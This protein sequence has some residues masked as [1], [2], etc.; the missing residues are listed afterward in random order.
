MKKLISI[1]IMVIMVT[2][3]MVPRTAEAVTIKL[4]KS[5]LLLGVGS[6]YVLHI[7]GTTKKVIWST[8]DSLVATVSTKGKV[9]AIAPGNATINATISKKKLICEI[10][11]N[12]VINNSDTEQA[13]Q[14][15]DESIKNED[16][17]MNNK[18]SKDIAAEMGKGWNLGNTMEAVATWLP[19]NAT[20]NDYE[21]AWG[22]PIT[23]KA[24]IDGLKA[25]GIN[26]VRIPVAWSNMM[27]KDGT[28]TISESYLKRVEEIIGYVL[29]NH[30]YAI[31][32]IHWDGGWWD[33]FASLDETKRINAMKKYQAMW[34]QIS[35]RYK[36]YSDHLIFES[37]NEELGGNFKKSLSEND[38]YK[39]CNEINQMFV[40]TVRNSGGNNK[41]RFL[42]I[43]GYS[44]DITATCDNR[45]SMPKDTLKNHLMISVHFYTPPTYCIADSEG[46]SWG[47]MDSWGSTKDISEMRA[48]FEKM[49]KFTDAGYGVIIG[50]YGVTL[51]NENGKKVMKKGS[52]QFIETVNKLASEMGYCAMLWDA[53]VWYNRIDCKF[54]DDKIA[55]IFKN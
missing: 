34:T 52:D 5:K 44:T 43:A 20:V 39:K 45:Y 46:N 21:K 14:K 48:Y 38:S 18:T 11:V 29:D 37:A 50:E 33:D 10:I 26:S 24:M 53:S 4:N 16:I 7:T 3:L 31:I 13:K 35:D 55:D 19:S 9:K 36:D 22:Q 12:K 32:N 2:T 1:V 6:S 54:N 23:T 25:N 27:S 49:K 41:T 17:D 8:S 47:Y 42:L 40:D 51:K 28:Y 30:M 15:T